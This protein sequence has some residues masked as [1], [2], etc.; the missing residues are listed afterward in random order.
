MND[1]IN[2]V[3][4]EWA[5]TSNTKRTA[6]RFVSCMIPDEKKKKTHGTKYF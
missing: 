4:R 1:F 5:K 3:D 6:G 2:R